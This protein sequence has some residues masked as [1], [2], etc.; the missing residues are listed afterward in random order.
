MSDIDWV[1]WAKQL[2]R[3]GQAK[4]DV[5]ILAELVAAGDKR[6]EK[7]TR[8]AAEAVL[9]EMDEKGLVE[10]P[11]RYKHLMREHGIAVTSIIQDS[12]VLEPLYVRKVE[13]SED[14]SQ[15]R[16]SSLYSNFDHEF[17]MEVWARLDKEPSGTVFSHPALEYI[18]KIWRTEDEKFREQVWRFGS[19]VAEYE[20]NDLPTLVKHVIQQHG[21][22]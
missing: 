17:D 19:L 10:W 18:G 11:E 15:E 22:A 9:K 7:A 20:S 5:E 4:Y 12:V 16:T 21:D 14:K 1:R 6:F 3:D 2:E 13:P 8:E